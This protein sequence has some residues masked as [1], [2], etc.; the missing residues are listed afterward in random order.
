MDKYADDSF[1]LVPASSD[2]SSNSEVNHIIHWASQNN[3]AV[4]IAK[5]KEI[6]FYSKP[7][8]P[9]VPPPLLASSIPR[10]SEINILGVTF[11]PTLAMTTHIANLTAKSHQ[12]LYALR[13]VKSHGLYGKHLH[14]VTQALLHSRLSYAISA[15]FGFANQENIMKLQ[16]V[17]DRA[18]RWGLG[19]NIPLPSI[20]HIAHKSDVALFSKVLRNPS[21][22]LHSLLPPERF[23]TTTKLRKRPHNHQL[24][25]SSTTAKKNFLTRMLFLNSY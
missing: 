5:C 2:S 21:H 25:L 4:N 3:M 16:R 24:A 19:G 8:A 17:I 9:H 14:E 20:E 18:E 10:V 23:S 15:W 12:T 13:L 22:I 6:I 11:D 1:L 7:S